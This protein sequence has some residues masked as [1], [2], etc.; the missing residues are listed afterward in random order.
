[1]QQTV[2]AKT[3]HKHV[4]TRNRDKFEAATAEDREHIRRNNEVGLLAKMATR[5]PLLDYDL[6]EPGDIA[7]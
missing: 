2:C 7:I 6:R 5:L 1:M 4:W 3:A